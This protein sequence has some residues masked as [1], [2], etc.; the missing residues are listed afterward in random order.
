MDKISVFEFWCIGDVACVQERDEWVIKV[1]P[2]EER[3]AH[4]EL[5]HSNPQRQST[6]LK[7]NGGEAVIETTSNNAV[8]ATWL[9]L[10]TLRKTPPN[11]R[12]GDQVLLYTL[13]KEMTYWVETNTMDEKRL[14]SVILAIS[15]DPKNKMDRVTW[16]NTYF[17]SMSSHDKRF[18]I[19]LNKVTDEFTGYSF[20]IDAKTAYAKLAD[21]LDNAVFID[22]RNTVVGYQNADGTTAYADK[23]NHITYAPNNIEMTAEQKIIQKAQAIILE[24]EDFKC[25]AKSTYKVIT[26]NAEFSTKITTPKAEI[27]GIEHSTHSHQEKG[28][29]KPVGGPQAG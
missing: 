13:G 2:R 19:R 6:T 25:T 20:D 14:E 16:E 12:H 11:V 23:L 29:G 18:H 9:G 4:Q 7:T 10:N 8:D 3:Y 24:C 26:P 5:V 17:I 15:A 22:S 21:D 28:D 1:T 27:N